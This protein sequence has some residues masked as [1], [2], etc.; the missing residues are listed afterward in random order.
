MPMM[1]FLSLRPTAHPQATRHDG[2][3]GAGRAPV[4]VNVTPL[5]GAL[6]NQSSGDLPGPRQSNKSF[7]QRDIGGNVGAP[8]RGFLVLAP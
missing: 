3:S 1:I 8:L 5:W 7:R 6:P 2:E 4:P